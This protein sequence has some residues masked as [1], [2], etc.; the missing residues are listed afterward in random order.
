MATPPSSPP[1]PTLLF[2]PD[3]SG[4]TAFV[5]DTAA[6]HS[7]HII[8]ELLEILIDANEIDLVVSEIEGDAVL[9]YR[10]GPPPSPAAILAQVQRMYVAFHAHLRKY[11][12]LRICQCGACRSAINLELKFVAH[13]GEAGLN[14][15][16][17]HTKLFGREVIVA[18]R[19][20]KNDLP[21]R[22]YVLLTEQLINR[23]GGTKAIEDAAWGPLEHGTGTYDFGS[24]DFGAIRLDPLRSQ[25]PEPA[26]EDYGLRGP[27]RKILEHEAVIAA[28]LDLVFNIV[29][30]LS[31]RHYW[32]DGLSGSD[33]LNSRITQAGATHRCIMKGTENDP[34]FVSHDFQVEE[35]FVTF[36]DTDHK[37]GICNVFTLRRIGERNTRF[38]LLCYMKQNFMMETMFKLFM[39]RKYEKSLA[40][41][42]GNLEAYCKDLLDRRDSHPAQILLRPE[43]A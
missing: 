27:T 31:A 38:A 34:F 35:D 8:E 18:H 24:I 29:S 26:I 3:I 23:C 39:K 7:K 19:L 37:S 41:S 25:V 14:R 6:V 30:D 12:R 17:E 13:Y 32:M 33:R 21:H 36:T 5:S 11:D 16:K 9:F 10:T 15:I 43:A 20:L 40:V 22:E 2:I 28:P 42:A 1:E 4:F